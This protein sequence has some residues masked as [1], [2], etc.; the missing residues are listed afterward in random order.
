MS[1]NIFKVG[2]P[3]VLGMYK[4]SGWS[5]IDADD[6]TLK[7]A[8]ATKPLDEWEIPN[9]KVIDD[10]P[11]WWTSPILIF[12]PNDYIFHWVNDNDDINLKV[13]IRVEPDMYDTE[14]SDILA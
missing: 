11:Y 7:L 5:K 1:L 2:Q 4:E 3:I 12:K 14:D 13:R 9:A 6:F 8:Y 10:D